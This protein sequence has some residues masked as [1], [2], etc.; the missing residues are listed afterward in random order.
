M[1]GRDVAL[2]LIGQDKSASKV[3]R[4]VGQEADRTRTK[5][6]SMAGAF[7]GGALA[8]G[9]VRFGKDSVRAFTEAQQAQERLTFAFAKFPKTADVNIDALRDYNSNLARVTKYDDD[10]IASG[11][12]V[13]AQFGLTGKQLQAST[14]L[15]L[16]YAAATG[17]ELPDAAETLGRAMMGNAR[18]LKAIGINYKSTGDSA[19]DFTNIQ[20]LVSAKVGGFAAKEGKTAA[21]QLAI[22]ENQ[23]GEVKEQVGSQLLPVLTTLGQKLLSTIDFVQRNS[24]VLK[25]L[26][27]TLGTVAAAVYAVNT[28]M[29]IGAATSAAYTAVKG[30]VTRA[31][32][33]EGVAATGAAAATNAL[34]AAETRAGAGGAASAAGS[35]V[36]AG[37]FRAVGASAATA[38]GSVVALTGAIA[39][40]AAAAL[41]F[42]AILR[43]VNN[44]ESNIASTKAGLP[45]AT[46]GSN[47]PLRQPDGTF[48]EPRNPVPITFGKPPPSRN[49]D[50]N[51]QPRGRLMSSGGSVRANSSSPTVVINGPVYGA[52]SDH[53]AREIAG[54]LKRMGTNGYTGGR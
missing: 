1:A 41:G 44:S 4:G 47:G 7:A 46:I 39:V 16:D 29:R 35:A 50:D 11:Q 5:F 27:I 17:K 6:A 33:A 13:M 28:A 9:A 20:A 42:L 31:S 21:G 36:A 43:R 45:T 32:A 12:A 48:I 8:V 37:G 3:L 26:A 22:L 25:P 49:G 38:L 54:S 40:G 30:L 15:L 18:A 53:L 2:R 14:P 24:G 52:S 34:A 23:F 10:A 51:R 19:K